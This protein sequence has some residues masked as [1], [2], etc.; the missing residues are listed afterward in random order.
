MKNWWGK[1]E[2]VIFGF[3]LVVI[4][5]DGYHHRSLQCRKQVEAWQGHLGH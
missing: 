1:E 3:G 2:N 5:L 4:K